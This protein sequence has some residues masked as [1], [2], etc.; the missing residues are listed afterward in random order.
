MIVVSQA[1]D[2]PDYFSINVDHSDN[3]L[4]ISEINISYIVNKRA[5]ALFYY[6]R[7]DVKLSRQADATRVIKA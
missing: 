6:V 7:N 3:L 2:S 4:R 5:S 1:K